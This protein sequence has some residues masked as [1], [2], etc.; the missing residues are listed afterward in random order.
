MQAGETSDPTRRTISQ[1]EADLVELE[2]SLDFCNST[3]R[4]QHFCNE[5]VPHYGEKR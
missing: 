5:V 3:R 1:W 4:R 2:N